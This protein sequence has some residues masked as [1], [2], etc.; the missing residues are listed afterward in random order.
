MKIS[1]FDGDEQVHYK[2]LAG[3]VSDYDIV[4]HSST[5]TTFPSLSEDAD[6]PPVPKID[7]ENIETENN[8]STYV[9][10][11]DNPDSLPGEIREAIFDWQV[12]TREQMDDWL[13]AND[14]S[15]RGG[16]VQ[17]ALIVLENVTEEIERIG[18]DAQKRIVWTGEDSS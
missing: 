4:I 5:E 1:V 8:R 14:R 15:P 11:R 13:E 7:P 16:S 10:L 18:S 12:V 6:V 9:R 3:D 2:E 17:T